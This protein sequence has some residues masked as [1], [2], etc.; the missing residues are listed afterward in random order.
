MKLVLNH[1]FKHQEQGGISQS[2]HICP[3]LRT[4]APR[5]HGH[6]PRS[7]PGPPMSGV[8]ALREPHRVGGGAAPLGKEGAGQTAPTD[9]SV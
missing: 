1:I 7:G 9:I 4:A 6:G 3:W 5:E 2:V 8:T